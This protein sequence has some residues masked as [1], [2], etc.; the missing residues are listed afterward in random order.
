MS[1]HQKELLQILT[2]GN[3]KPKFSRDTLEIEAINDFQDMIAIYK[4]IK[5]NIYTLDVSTF[6]PKLSV[7]LQFFR[8]L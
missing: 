8:T 3:D 6:D 7:C 2:Y 4:N 1:G 5:S